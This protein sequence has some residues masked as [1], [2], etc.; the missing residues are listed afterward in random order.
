MTHVAMTP[1]VELDELSRVYQGTPPVPALRATNLRVSTGESVAVMGR[2]GSGKSTLLHLLGLLDR[3]TAGRYLLDGHDTAAMSDRQLTRLRGRRI[4]FVF[5]NFHLMPH[6]PALENVAVALL[7]S[8]A[9]P[10]SARRS[11]AIEALDRVGLSD[12]AHALPRTL[13]GG[14][15]QRVAIARALA[16]RPALMLADEPTGNLDSATADE[17]LS[18]FD[19]LHR[20]GQTLVIVTHD[21]AVAA[22]AQRRLQINDGTLSED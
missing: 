13:S 1:V 8:Q 12:R 5:Q 19:D 11:R 4:G 16:A 6:R 10:R 3:P 20:D 7:Y 15:R 18:H 9:C 2:S 22:R 17:V 21:P 14:E